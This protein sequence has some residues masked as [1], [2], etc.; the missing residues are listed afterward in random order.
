MRHVQHLPIYFRNIHK[1]QLQHTFEMTETPQ[2]YICNIGERKPGQV[3][4]L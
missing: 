1:K 4:L 3:D 2:A